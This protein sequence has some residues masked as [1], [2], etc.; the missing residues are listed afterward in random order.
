MEGSQDAEGPCGNHVHA[1]WPK[2]GP[3]SRQFWGVPNWLAGSIHG[4]R[5][6][7]QNNSVPTS[8]NMMPNA[9]N[10]MAA[11]LVG[12]GVRVVKEHATINIVKRF[13]KAHELEHLEAEIIECLKNSVRSRWQ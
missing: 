1:R 2:Q 5:E 11:Q 13:P 10:A 4:L 8:P 9:V 3:K 7:V 6:P 12:S